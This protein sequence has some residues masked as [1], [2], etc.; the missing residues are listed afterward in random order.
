MKRL[1]VNEVQTFREHVRAQ[2]R[3]AAQVKKAEKE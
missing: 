2:A 1:I 3:A